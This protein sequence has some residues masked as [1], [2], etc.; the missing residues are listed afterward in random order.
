M[1][2][3]HQLE[4]YQS[5]YKFIKLMYEVKIKLPKILKY[6][7]GRL[8]C[9]SSLKLLRGVI[10]ANGSQDKS[11]VLNLM[12][13]EID[14]IWQYLRLMYELKAISKGEFQ[15]LSQTL[16]NISDHTEKWLHWSKQ[17]NIKKSESKARV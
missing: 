16:A 7:L 14:V 13:V 2:K 5:V 8:S 10:I 3:F 4:I 12:A 6:D 15:V 1:A 9:E 11:K 17:Q